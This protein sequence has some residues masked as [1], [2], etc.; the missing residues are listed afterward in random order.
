ME[1]S[2]RK[3]GTKPSKK[4]PSASVK[5]IFSGEQPP[6]GPTGMQ[7]VVKGD[8][9]AAF[10]WEKTNADAVPNAKRLWFFL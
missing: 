6:A 1:R 4:G 7:A 10:H 8:L 3:T 5:P 9:R 2:F